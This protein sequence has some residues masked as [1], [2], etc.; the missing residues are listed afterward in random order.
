S[1]QSTVNSQQSTVNSQQSPKDL[2]VSNPPYI[3]YKERAEMSAGVLEHEPDIALFVPNED[4]LIF[5]RAIANY[6]LLNLKKG[7]LLFYEINP[8]CA[9]EMHEMLTSKG[10]SNIEIR[11]DQ[12]GKQRMLKATLL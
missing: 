12:F 11:K 3:M 6:A 8:L 7:G 5:Y 9:T 10:F 2:I 4:P 1:Q